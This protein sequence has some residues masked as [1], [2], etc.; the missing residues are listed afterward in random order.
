MIRSVAATKVVPRPPGV[1]RWGVPAR[2]AGE[3][4]PPPAPLPYPTGARTCEHS[5]LRLGS[6]KRRTL[7]RTAPW[8]LALAPLAGTPTSAEAQEPADTL[9]VFR[10]SPLEVTILRTWVDPSMLPY[11]VSV[12]DE[13]ELRRGR[14]GAFIEEALTAVPGIQVQ[15]R[16]NLAQ[17]ER[18]SVRGFGAR[19]QFG[20][21][22]VRVLIDGIPATLPDGQT[23]LENL[24]LGSVGRVEILRGPGSALYGNAAGGVLAFRSQ[25][26]P[27]LPFR[28]E[29]RGV[30]GSNA[31]HTVDLTASGTSGD[32]GYMVALGLLGFDGFRDLA[33]AAGSYGEADRK[34]VNARLSRPLGRGELAVTVN[35]V[36]QEG[37]NPGALPFELFAAGDRRAWR[38]NVAQR[39]S[40]ATSQ[41]QAGATWEAPVAGDLGL[42]AAAWY[43]HRDN[44]GFIPPAVIALERDAF[45]VRGLL[46]GGEGL[47]GWD[48][49]AE[50]E[51]QR[52]DRLNWENDGGSRGALTLDQSETVRGLSAFVQGRLRPTERVLLSG[53]L[54]YDRFRFEADDDFVEGGDPDDS[55]SRVMDAFNPT[56]GVVW[57]AAPG[58]TL[59]VNVATALETPTTT[60]LTNRPDG[61]GGFNPDLE[62]ARGVTLEGG[63][64]GMLG[65]RLRY[66]LVGFRTRVEDE[67]VPFE[68]PEVPGR[69][70]FRNAGSSV[71]RGVEAL[72][73][74]ALGSGL[75]TRLALTRI[76]A[77]FEDYVV[78]GE[79]LGGHRVPGLA[80]T[81]LEGW[82]RLDRPLG[83]AELNGEWVDAIP[84]DDANTAEAPSHTLLGLRAGLS[85]RPLAG[86][87]VAPFVGVSNLTD[88]V[89]ATSVIVN[90]FGGRYYEPGPGRTWYVG[91]RTGWTP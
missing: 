23:A 89:H 27:A 58:A 54:R 20:V 42:E 76:D 70:F 74:A 29:V 72:L 5:P 75:S 12:L 1:M 30:V 56:V 44:E 26:P 91:V 71:H 37:E 59:F 65:E 84:V 87:E 60:E 35:A 41:A 82:L 88:E 17:G 52:D 8:L 49:G 19:A 43:I 36:D 47:F 22:G 31:L 64:R 2:D 61:A 68:V 40:E 39:T 7:R 4:L 50:A 80:P 67:L 66:E 3:P 81:R 51:L 85:P 83:F 46:R 79:D 63:V 53:A 32:L 55:G 18:L 62:P 28:Q 77:R 57:R 69:S 16:Y 21:R 48:A 78:E 73:E 10:V 25:A 38:G 15:N 45:G 9:P 34:S 33:D 11:A 13:S 86:I 24:H 90:A 6:M 14:T